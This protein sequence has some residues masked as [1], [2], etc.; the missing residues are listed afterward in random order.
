VPTWR[1]LPDNLR[2]AVSGDIGSDGIDDD[3][4]DLK[5]GICELRA[6]SGTI[7]AIWRP[8]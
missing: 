6:S 3:G 1:E 4:R 7:E 5:V 2:N 8:P